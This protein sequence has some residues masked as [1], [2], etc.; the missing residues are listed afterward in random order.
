[1]AESCLQMFTKSYSKVVQTQCNEGI[2]KLS[3]SLQQGTNLY[4]QVLPMDKLDAGLSIQ[5]VSSLTVYGQW[6]H[7]EYSLILLLEKSVL[8][9]S[10]KC[11]EDF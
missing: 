1:M 2:T 9:I 5:P 7:F 11:L 3:N 8:I 6:K 10:N 4:N